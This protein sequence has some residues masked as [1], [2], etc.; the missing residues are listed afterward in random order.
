MRKNET[1]MNIME[2]IFKLTGTVRVVMLPPKKCIFIH[3]YQ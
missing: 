2:N 1:K 3:V